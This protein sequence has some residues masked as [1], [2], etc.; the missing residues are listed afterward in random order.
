[1]QEQWLLHLNYQKGH[2]RFVFVAKYCQKYDDKF[3]TIMKGGD[4]F[5]PLMQVLGSKKMNSSIKDSER[6]R[7]LISDGKYKVNIAM[8]TVQ[9]SD[10]NVEHALEMF[11]IIKLKRHLS[12]VIKNKDKRD[13]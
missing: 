8:Y 2:L 12:N 4:V 10:E 7:L 6:Y 3:Q 5:E 11:S 9:M 1:M 13:T